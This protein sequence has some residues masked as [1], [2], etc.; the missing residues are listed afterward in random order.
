MVNTWALSKSSWW[1]GLGRISPQSHIEWAKSEVIWGSFFSTQIPAVKCCIQIYLDNHVLAIWYQ[2]GQFYFGMSDLDPKLAVLVAH[3]N[4]RSKHRLPVHWQSLQVRLHL[5]FAWQ[6][7]LPIHLCFFSS[8]PCTFSKH[9]SSSHLLGANPRSLVV[10]P[11][12]RLFLCDLRV[13]S[14]W[15]NLHADL[16]RKEKNITKGKNHR[17]KEKKGIEDLIVK[18]GDTRKLNRI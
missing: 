8:D 1:L 7:V 17:C 4:F 6:L 10:H 9:T 16:A 2:Q 15:S 13:L 14:G 11:D 18:T 3:E 12:P 5:R